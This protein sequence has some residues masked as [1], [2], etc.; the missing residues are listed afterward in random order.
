MHR[1]E[2]RRTCCIF[3]ETELV[4]TFLVVSVFFTSADGARGSG[5]SGL[6]PFGEVWWV[7]WIPGALLRR[8]GGHANG[9]AAGRS[10]VLVHVRLAAGDPQAR[11]SVP[12]LQT[13]RSV[14][15][16]CRAKYIGSFAICQSQ[17]QSPSNYYADFLISCRGDGEGSC[18]GSE[19]REHRLSNQ[20]QS[21]PEPDDHGIQTAYCTGVPLFPVLLP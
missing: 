16:C 13:W 19:E 12:A 11:A 21:I 2:S 10:Q 1:K 8:W 14:A 7:P 3:I 6:L 18:C 15:C 17:T 4:T 20:C 9:P 5:L